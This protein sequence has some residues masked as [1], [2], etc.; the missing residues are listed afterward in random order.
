MIQ[1]IDA[2]VVKTHCDMTMGMITGYHIHSDW[3]FL[4]FHRTYLEGMEDFLIAQGH[5]EFVPLPSWNPKIHAP[6]EFEHGGPNL[7]GIDPD[8]GSPCTA[9]G[10]T[11]ACDIPMNWDPQNDRADYPALNRPGLCDWNMEPSFPDPSNMGNCC[12]NG[13]SRKIETPYHD[14]THVWMGDPDNN[15]FTPNGVMSYFRS[16]AA[17]IFWIW[18]AYVD[19]I[20]KEWEEYCPDVALPPVDLYMKD[21]PKVVESERDRGEEPNIDTDPMWLSEDIWVH[22]QINDGG[23]DQEH[24]NPDHHTEGGTNFVYVRVRNRGY[25]A[26]APGVPLRLYWAKAAT[27]LAWPSF[28]NGSITDPAL[29]GEEIQAGH[30]LPSIPAG[31]SHIEVFEWNAPN[32]A[33]YNAVGTN[34]IFWANEPWHFC[35]LARIETETTAPFGMTFPETADLNG[36][37]NQNNNIIW[38]N[39]SVIDIAGMAGGGG[40]WADDKLVGASVLTGDAWGHG[41]RFNLVFK[42]PD[43][44]KGNPVTAEAEVRVT[45]DQPLWEAWQASGGQ[46]EN[47]SI[48]REDRHQ[49][50]VT[51]SPA[52]LRNIYYPAG[53]RWL[54]HVSF[55]FLAKQL[56][57]QPL[58]D[59]DFIQTDESER[60]VGG[61]RYH[62]IV[63]GKEGFYADAGPDKNVSPNTAVNLSAY[64]VDEAAIYNWYDP[65]GELIYTGKDM[66]VSPEI[67]SKYKLEVIA[68]SDGVKDY[69]EVEVKVK[70]H[71]VTNIAPNPATGN[72]IITYRLTNATSAYLILTMPYSG[73]N[74]QYILNV[75]N[76]QVQLNVNDLPPGTY[77]LILVVDGIPSDVD[78]ITIL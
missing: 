75:A 5:P 6:D 24:Q 64:T 38:K 33:D 1:Y 55:N 7:D 27:A 45:L 37:V 26:S 71:E 72:T 19:D 25:E 52:K 59:F 21:T 69:D 76:D 60:A 49:L 18:H 30:V 15:Q 57:G 32:P 29:M 54:A 78:Q 3:D 70:E 42:N 51:G 58:F 56:S 11:S 39:I 8:C 77:S 22:N 73:V 13:L 53:K 36:N 31:G 47:M 40:G 16:P 46:M 35:L 44:Y 10:P 34:P 68:E 48:S 23:A 20:W 43:H 62:V 9:G 63:P 50:I 17:P 74:N 65:Q 14:N 61:E 2:D 12:P 41:G 66:T 4:P 67:T 28:W